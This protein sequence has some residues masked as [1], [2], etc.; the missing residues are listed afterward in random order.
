MGLALAWT[1][2][3]LPP[4]S[5][6]CLFISE[7]PPLFYLCW[8]PACF[9]STQRALLARH[10]AAAPPAARC[11]CPRP[12]LPYACRRQRRSVAFLPLSDTCN[13]NEA[14]ETRTPPRPAR[15][16][17]IQPCSCQSPALPP[18]AQLKAPTSPPPPPFPRAAPPPPTHPTHHSPPHRHHSH[19]P[20]PPTRPASSP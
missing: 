8:D 18:T 7:C 16:P 10:Q 1:Y 15:L 11:C 6:P 14:P 3:Q 9:F 5:S 20:P 4:A 13:C 12:S 17:T 2:S 19:P